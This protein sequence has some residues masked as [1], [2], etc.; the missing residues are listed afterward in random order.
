MTAY[1]VSR[2]SIS[3]RE[4]MNGYMAEAPASVDAYGGKYL[5]RT[6]DIT[7]LEGNAPYERVVVVEFPSKERALAWYNSNEYRDLRDIRWRSADAHIICV[8]GEAAESSTVDA[9]RR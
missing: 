2:V 1:I 6:G 4:A 7:V 8:P 9:D 3:D 5:V